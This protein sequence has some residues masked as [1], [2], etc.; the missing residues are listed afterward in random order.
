[1]SLEEGGLAQRLEDRADEIGPGQ[2]QL[3]VDRAGEPIG[4][5]N[6]QLERG[7]YLQFND[8]PWGHGSFQRVNRLGRLHGTTELPIVQQLGLVLPRPIERQVL[9]GSL[10]PM[11]SKVRIS[12]SASYSP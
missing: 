8:S 1:G 4:K 10:P 6:P 2:K 7:P 5:A 12:T 3:H 9:R 11:T